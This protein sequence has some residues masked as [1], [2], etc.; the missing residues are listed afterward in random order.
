MARSFE[1]EITKEEL[2]QLDRLL[3]SLALLSDLDEVQKV[4]FIWSNLYCRNMFGYS[5]EFDKHYKHL[6][7]ERELNKLHSI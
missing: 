2:I 1:I 6:C 7:R 4:Y 5:L 3:H